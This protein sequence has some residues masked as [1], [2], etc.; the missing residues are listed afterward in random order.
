MKATTVIIIDLR[1]VLK[2]GKYPVKLRVTFNRKQMYY[3]AD[4][5][6]LPAEFDIVRGK[7]PKGD[8]K[9][10]KLQ[11]DALEQRANK[12]IEKKFQEITGTNFSESLNL[13]VI[14]QLKEQNFVT[15]RP[16]RINLTPKGLLLHSY[17]VPRM[18]I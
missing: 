16:D 11:L 10:W 9:K 5:S 4:L 8:Y 13:K 15:M 2:N 12:V 17:I 1:K 3:P 14:E 18:L 7:N 6:L